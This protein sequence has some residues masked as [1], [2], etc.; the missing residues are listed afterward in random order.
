MMEEITTAFDYD[1]ENPH[2]NCFPN[3]LTPLNANPMNAISCGGS[4]KAMGMRR[5]KSPD[6]MTFT[7]TIATERISMVDVT[8]MVK[9]SS[10]AMSI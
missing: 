1:Y 6:P 5:V 10:L 9:L 3:N 7:E 8:R 4:M 2:I